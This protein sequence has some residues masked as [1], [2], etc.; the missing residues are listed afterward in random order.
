MPPPAADGV[1]AGT[2]QPAGQQRKAK[3]FHLVEVPDAFQPYDRGKDAGQQSA[4]QC[5]ERVAHALARDVQPV[6]GFAHQ[7]EGAGVLRPAVEKGGADGWLDSTALASSITGVGVAIKVAARS[8]TGS[9]RGAAGA[10][11]MPAAWRRATPRAERSNCP[12]AAAAAGDCTGGSLKMSTAG[13]A[14]AGGWAGPATL[15]RPYFLRNLYKAMRETRSPKRLRDELD[16]FGLAGL[17]MAQKESGDR[18]GVARQEFA[19]GR[20][21][22]RW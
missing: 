7:Q 19:V 3:V 17:G 18:T 16:Q 8:G 15:F 9:N 4:R 5:A 10:M 21:S 6:E 22:M 11:S 2:T 12:G 14:G 20:P 1:A 13:L